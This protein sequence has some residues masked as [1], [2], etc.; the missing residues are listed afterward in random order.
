MKKVA[1]FANFFYVH[2]YSFK[3][4]KVDQSVHLFFSFPTNKVS[5]KVKKSMLQNNIYN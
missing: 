3:D 4:A 5:N 1:T 2:S